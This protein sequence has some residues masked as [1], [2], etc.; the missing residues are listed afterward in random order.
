QEYLTITLG[1]FGVSEQEIILIMIE[2]GI[3]PNE[4]V[5][6][7][8]DALPL[9]KAMYEQLPLM[10]AGMQDVSEGGHSVKWN[11]E[12]IKLWYSSLAREL[13]LPDNLVPKPVA[14]GNSPW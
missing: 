9:K 7:K 8:A 3:D 4:L 13:G 12:G 2:Q 5:T 1:K 6:G 11:L 14:R 10:L